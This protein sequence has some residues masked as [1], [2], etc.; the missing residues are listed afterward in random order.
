MHGAMF[1]SSSGILGA[2]FIILLTGIAGWLME[3]INEKM[4]D[5][6]IVSSWLPHGFVNDLASTFAMFTI[7]FTIS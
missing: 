2:I 1:L 3:W 6:S 7:M 5:G 4:S